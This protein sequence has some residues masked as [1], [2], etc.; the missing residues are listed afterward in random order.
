MRSLSTTVAPEG[1]PEKNR[2]PMR[3]RP[4]NEELRLP[5]SMHDSFFSFVR[6]TLQNTYVM[7]SAFGN[8]GY[9][10]LESFKRLA[11][12]LGEKEKGREAVSGLLSFF[13]NMEKQYFFHRGF[14][15]LL[16]AEEE[17]AFSASL[18]RCRK[19]MEKLTNILEGKP[20]FLA[21]EEV[22]LERLLG[23]VMSLLSLTSY[24]YSSPSPITLYADRLDMFLLFEN[25][26]S[27]SIRACVR[28]GAPPAVEIIAFPS[29]Q[30]PGMA[31]ITVKDEGIG[32]TPGELLAA[33]ERRRFTTK[34]KG[35]EEL[36][37]IGLMHC[38]FIVEQHGGTFSIYS[39]KPFGSEISF[40]LPI[41]Q[42]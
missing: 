13:S 19:E 24:R 14:D 40:S 39:R 18:S 42:G 21:R 25:L 6:H 17:R 20:H 1:K 16:N 41:K 11:G 33:E 28:K 32:F 12:M 23:D 5:T 9:S 7:L 15:L 4:L 27:N 37:G 2:F 31:E 22:S 30:N 34:E 36:H 35:G 26:S 38:R 29:D 8:L 10:D 3:P